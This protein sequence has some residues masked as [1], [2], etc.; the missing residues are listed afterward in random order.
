MTITVSVNDLITATPSSSCDT[1]L[2]RGPWDFDLV[3][4]YGPGASEDDVIP[5]P[6]TRPGQLPSAYEGMREDELHAR[7]HA[8][9]KRLARGAS[10]R[11]SNRL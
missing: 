4:G 2:A 1:E 6:V 8:D 11:L 5:A 10:E 3:P 9:K 7:D